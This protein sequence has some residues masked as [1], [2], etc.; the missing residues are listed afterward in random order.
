MTTPYVAE[1]L[2]ELLERV[3]RLES[4]RILLMERVRELEKTVS[5]LQNRGV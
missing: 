4:E 1:T 2:K 5:Y 3:D